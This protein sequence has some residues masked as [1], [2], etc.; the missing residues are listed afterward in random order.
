MITDPTWRMKPNWPG[1]DPRKRRPGESDRDYE[2]RMARLLD[3]NLA[4]RITFFLLSG[5]LFFLATDVAMLLVA[6]RAEGVSDFPLMPIWAPALGVCAAI[7]GVRIVR[8]C[9][10]PRARSRPFDWPENRRF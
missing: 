9:R 1:P 6:G 2:G 10:A 3:G 4:R 8:R 7:L 5:G